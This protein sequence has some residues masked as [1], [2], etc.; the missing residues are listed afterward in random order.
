LAVIEIQLLI[1]LVKMVIM[2][3]LIKFVN[4]VII[5]VLN[6]HYLQEIVQNVKDLIGKVMLLHVDVI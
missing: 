1:A 5:I 3:T 6:V 2:K 4:N